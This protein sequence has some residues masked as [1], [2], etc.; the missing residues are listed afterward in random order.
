MDCLSSYLQVLL[1]TLLRTWKLGL[2][3]RAQLA[4][5]I[6]YNCAGFII[7][8]LC[9]GVFVVW[10]GGLVVGDRSA[11]KAVLNI[12]QLFY[13]SLFLVIFSS[14]YVVGCMKQVLVSVIKQWKLVLVL[15]IG[16]IIIIHFNTHV[17]PYLLAD[18]RHYTFYI[19]KRLYERHFLMKYLLIPIYIL[20]A[21]SASH[22]LKETD[23]AFQTGYF[24]F[25]MLCLVPQKLLEFRYF[26]VPFL[27][28]RLHICLKAWWQ[29]VAEFLLFFCINASTIYLF[30]TKTFYWSNS[31]EVQRF[32]W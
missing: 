10:N 1:D 32:L 18:N 14:P 9:F 3:S 6:L 15:V 13:F 20:G 11:H 4:N 27:M 7:V 17:H 2:T 19:W 29:L 5:K 26:I 30:M 23:V 28:L 25:I 12:P 8:G 31:E 22:L 16:C 24:T 21:F